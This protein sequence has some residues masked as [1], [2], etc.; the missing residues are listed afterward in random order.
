MKRAA[1]RGSLRRISSSSS[2][3]KLSPISG[4]LPASPDGAYGLAC[5][6]S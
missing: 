1:N 4:S 6:A 2:K 5:H 3:S